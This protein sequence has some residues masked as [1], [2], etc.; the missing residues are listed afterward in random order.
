MVSDAP[1]G[2]KEWLAKKDIEMSK[3]ADSGIAVILDSG[4]AATRRNIDRLLQQNKDVYVYELSS[5]GRASDRSVKDTL[6]F[7]TRTAAVSDLVQTMQSDIQYR[8]YD[9]LRSHDEVARSKSGDCHSQVQYEYE[10]LKRMGV[11]EPK[12]LFMVEYNPKTNAG[13]STHSACYYTDGGK[14][15][16]IENAWSDNKGMHIYKSEDDLLKDIKKK[17]VKSGDKS[18]YS[19]IATSVYDPSKHEPGE[20]LQEFIDKCLT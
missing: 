20:T 19:E 10:E 18:K 7:S 4:A 2:S 8:E 12:A 13:G 14:A 15:I 5:R 1:E 11:L 3:D 9:K 17:F 16:W 6:A